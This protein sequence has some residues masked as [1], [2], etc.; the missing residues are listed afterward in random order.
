MSPPWSPKPRPMSHP[1]SHHRAYFLPSIHRHLESSVSF[2][3]SGSVSAPAHTSSPGARGWCAQPADS[4]GAHLGLSNPS[5]GHPSGQ[6]PHRAAQ[7]NPSAGLTS[8]FPTFLFCGQ[9]RPLLQAQNPE[10]VPSSVFYLDH[11]GP[12][13]GPA[14]PSPRQTCGL[15]VGRISENICDTIRILHPSGGGGLCYLSYCFLGDW[16]VQIFSISSGVSWQ[17]YTSQERSLCFIQVF[18]RV[19]TVGRAELVIHSRLLLSLSPLLPLFL[20]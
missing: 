7:T 20:S 13:A 10:S 2:P 12:Q 11:L 5:S 19:Q 3:S 15:N 16:S 17:D 4:T 14:G 8:S 9:L 18:Q 1:V 6:R